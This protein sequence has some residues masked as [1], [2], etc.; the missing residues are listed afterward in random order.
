MLIESNSFPNTWVKSIKHVLREGKK[1]KFGGKEYLKNA[2]DTDLVIVMSYKA[3]QQAL[4]K[5]LHPQYPNKEHALE[6]YIKE[7]EPDYNIQKRFP[8]TYGERCY[9]YESSMLDSVETNGLTVTAIPRMINQI[10]LSRE[11]L[12]EQVKGNY[13]SNR[14]TICIMNPVDRIKIPESMPCLQ[15]INIRYEGHNEVSVKWLFRSHDLYNAWMF[16]VI[17]LLNMINNEIVKPCGCEIVKLIEYNESMH[18]YEHNIE[19][20]KKV[21]LVPINPQ[22]Y[23]YG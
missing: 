9:R 19:E 13:Q 11:C 4:N 16:N 17:A 12:Q 7:F 22:E 6:S 15:Q 3:I 23:R 14:N 20:A 2:I 18:I 5:E 21:K 1:I 10:K 8:Y